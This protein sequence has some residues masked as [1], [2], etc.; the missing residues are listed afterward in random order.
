MVLLHQLMVHAR[1]GSIRLL[2]IYLLQQQRFRLY[3]TS[4]VV[5]FSTT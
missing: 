4:I 3:R 2:Q 5:G 1:Y